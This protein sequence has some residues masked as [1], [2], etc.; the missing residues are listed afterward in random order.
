MCVC[1]C[2][3]SCICMCSCGPGSRVDLSNVQ[4]WRASAWVHADDMEH[5][6]A[7]VR[8]EE[9]GRESRRGL[10]SV[11]ARFCCRPD[12]TPACERAPLRRAFSVLG[13]WCG[14]PTLRAPPQH[15]LRRHFQ[16]LCCDE[17]GRDASLPST[18]SQSAPLRPRRNVVRIHLS[19]HRPKQHLTSDV[20]RRR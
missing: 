9:R 6:R 11:C 13:W 5:A 19:L 16:P 4:R 1:L 3:C 7:L 17:A 18:P 12:P 20:Q 15:V 10:E 8:R 14:T 2:I